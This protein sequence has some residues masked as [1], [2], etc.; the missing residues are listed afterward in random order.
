MARTVAE[1]LEAVRSASTRTDSIIADRAETKRRLEEALAAGGAMTPEV[2]AA[3]DEIF[4]IETADA[5][6]IDDALNAN[7]PPAEPPAEPAV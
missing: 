5:K 3:L 6:K 4:D 1:T 2:Q 7:V